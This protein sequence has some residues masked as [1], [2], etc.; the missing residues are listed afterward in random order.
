MGYLDYIIIGKDIP[1]CLQFDQNDH[2]TLS[3]V[4]IDPI[5]YSHNL[6]YI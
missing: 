5:G 2:K 1:T 3:N 4:E 6:C